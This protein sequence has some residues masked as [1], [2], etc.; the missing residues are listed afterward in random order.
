M[1]LPFFDID[2]FGGGVNGGTWTGDFKVEALVGEC[3]WAVLVDFF[4]FLLDL[5]LSSRAE[6]AAAGALEPPVVLAAEELEATAPA[7]AL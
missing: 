6:A 4:L 7:A 2:F 3:C 5:S 1:F